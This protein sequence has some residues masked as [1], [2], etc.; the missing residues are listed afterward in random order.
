VV[1]STCFYIGNANRE[2][3]NMNVR[4]R[5]QFGNLASG[6]WCAGGRD[7]IAPIS[8]GSAAPPEIQKLLADFRTAQG[9]VLNFVRLSGSGSGL[10][11]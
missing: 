7:Q 2:V 5:D 11:F 8:T 1:M 3:R 6:T 4:S 10:E 9:Q